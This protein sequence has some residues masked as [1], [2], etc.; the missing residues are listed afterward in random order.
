MTN[1]K[2]IPRSCG[3]NLAE[4]SF[5]IILNSS[6]PP[7]GLYIGLSLNLSLFVLGLIWSSLESD[8]IFS[9]AR[10]G[11]VGKLY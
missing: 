5:D 3:F 7:N 2:E 9:A 1:Q 4:L 10:G 6:S 11:V 8:F